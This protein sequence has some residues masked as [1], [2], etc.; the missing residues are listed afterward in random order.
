[1]L[2]G[3]V[4]KNDI[5]RIE[6]RY[7]GVVAGEDFLS[8]GTLQR[9]ETKNAFGIVLQDKPDHAVAKSA[10]AIVKDEGTAQLF[11][12][13]TSS[14]VANVSIAIPAE[15]TGEVATDEAAEITKRAR[16][17]DWKLDEI[18]SDGVGVAGSFYMERGRSKGFE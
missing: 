17:K 13:I 6:G 14:L 2:V 16:A 8:Q 7:V 3:I 9:G 11:S 10:D 12:R 1:M 18:C 5:E 15:Q 4:V